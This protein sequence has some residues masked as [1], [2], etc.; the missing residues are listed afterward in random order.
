ML[1]QDLSLGFLRMSRGGCDQMCMSHGKFFVNIPSIFHKSW[2]VVS[3]FH[4]NPCFG[5]LDSPC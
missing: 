2:E 4:L 3:G 5:Q 1:I